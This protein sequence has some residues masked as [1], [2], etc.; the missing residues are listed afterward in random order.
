MSPG[1]SDPVDSRVMPFS[2]PYQERSRRSCGLL[3]WVEKC[4]GN[5]L[6]FHCGACLLADGI[7]FDSCY[8]SRGCFRDRAAPGN[9]GAVERESEKALLV[10]R[11]W[12]C[13]S[14]SRPVLKTT[15]VSLAV[16]L[17]LV[18]IYPFYYEWDQVG[19]GDFRAAAEYIQRN[20]GENDVICH[21][22][23]N[24][25]EIFN[26]YFNW[27]VP[28]VDIGDVSSGNYVSDGAI[29]LVVHEQKG[30]FEFS[31]ESFRAASVAGRG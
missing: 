12:H 2:L 29:W 6:S 30:G 4:G 28:Q 8:R 20:W 9:S 1:D 14:A 26:Y 23:Y 27:R 16:L 19:K 24:T 31:R 15:L 5:P 3:T 11:G 17:S 18:S 22:K 10:A 25:R 7:E 21:T 13:L